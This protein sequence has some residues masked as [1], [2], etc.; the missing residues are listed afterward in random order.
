MRENIDQ[1]MSQI[2]VTAV[3][4]D[5]ISSFSLTQG[6]TLGDLADHLAQAEEKIG[7]KPIAVGIKFD[8]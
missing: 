8:A 1:P 4:E 3:Y 5:K 6:A 7:R 2:W